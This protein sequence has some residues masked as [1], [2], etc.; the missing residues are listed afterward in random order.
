MMAQRVQFRQV[1]MPFDEGRSLE[2]DR[3]LNVRRWREDFRIIRETG[4]CGVD[5]EGGSL[6]GKRLTHVG[7]YPEATFRRLLDLC[8]ESG[9]DVHL[10][11]FSGIEPLER[12]VTLAAREGWL[13]RD[14]DG[15]ELP[16]FNAYNPDWRERWLHPFLRRTAERYGEHP[17]MAGYRVGDVW[18]VPGA[19]GEPERQRFREFLKR[20]Y[21]ALAAVGAAW[22]ERFRSW[23]HIQP[24]QLPMPWQQRWLDWTDAQGEW[25][26]ALAADVVRF[27]QDVPGAA[28]EVFIFAPC[29]LTQNSPEY[30]AGFTEEFFRAFQIIGVC[31]NYPHERYSRDVGLAAIDRSLAM[32]KVLAPHARLALADMPGPRWSDP[33]PDDFYSAEWMIEMMQLAINRGAT[34]VL[35]DGYRKA[36]V[37]TAVAYAQT[38]AYHARILQQLSEFHQQINA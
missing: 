9:L 14:E 8:H 26:A 5:M 10:N 29:W 25:L 28:H 7:Y 38:F 35:Y 12:D 21:G 33:G 37:A 34:Y 27:L 22:R 30:Y 13:C 3:P 20:R 11:V 19:P 36:H 23:D 24:P 15:R 32:I 6:F 1:Y 2:P 18:Q 31:G 17:A 4:H 16:V